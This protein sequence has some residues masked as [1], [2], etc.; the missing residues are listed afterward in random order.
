VL[1]YAPE[2]ALQFVDPDRKELNMA[3]HF[4]DVGKHISDFGLEKYKSFFPDMSRTKGWLSIFL[5]SITQNGSKFEMK[6]QNLENYL[7][8]C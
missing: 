5:M 4:E 2:D 1:K 3:Y 7:L 6:L 8:R